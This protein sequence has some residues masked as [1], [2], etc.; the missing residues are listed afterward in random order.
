M[1]QFELFCRFEGFF[2]VEGGENGKKKRKHEAFVAWNCKCVIQS[3]CGFALA[4]FDFQFISALS[5][6]WQYGEFASGD[7]VEM[8]TIDVF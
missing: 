2:V 1:Y 4:Q 3:P 7:R 6:N 5:R 8:P